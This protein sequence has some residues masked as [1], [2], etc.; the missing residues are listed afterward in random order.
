MH[1]K[2]TYWSLQNGYEDCERERVGVLGVP[3]PSADSAMVKG[4][5]QECLGF[6]K[7][8]HFTEVS[9]ADVS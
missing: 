5:I 9:L 1:R 4:I 2:N 3:F 7:S 8:E 6:P